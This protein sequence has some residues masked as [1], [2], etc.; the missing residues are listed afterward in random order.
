MSDEEAIQKSSVDRVR[1]GI[2]V[3]GRH[4][5]SSRVV[6]QKVKASEAVTGIG[7]ALAIDGAKYLCLDKASE[8]ITTSVEACQPLSL[9]DE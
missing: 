9:A 1:S 7:R 4:K 5:A 3:L 8:T 6:M 2:D